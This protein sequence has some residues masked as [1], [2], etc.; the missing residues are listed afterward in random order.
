MI[1]DDDPS[2]TRL[3][4]TL[5]RLEGYEALQLEDW[6]DPEKDIER[7]RPD[8]IIMDVRL[9]SRSGF[10]L[11]AAIRSAPDPVLARTPVLMMSV[12]DHRVQSRRA[13]ANG[14]VAKPFDLAALAR[15]IREVEGG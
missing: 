14:F 10:D 11:L 1:V 5:L 6:A 8:L 3:L 15:A 2:G 13:G 9:R 7:Q 12:D 4:A